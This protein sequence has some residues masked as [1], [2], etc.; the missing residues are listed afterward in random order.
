MP[1]KW[2]AAQ[3]GFQPLLD[4]M[5]PHPGDGGEAD[6]EGLGDALVG[7]GGTAVGLVG[8]EQDAGMGQ[9]AGRSLPPA[10]RSWRDWRSSVVNVTKYFFIGGSSQ[11]N[12]MRPETAALF[13]STVADH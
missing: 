13:K 1:A 7:P 4:E 11:R 6:V 2:L 8:L 12:P 10:V 5:L 9:F 3:G